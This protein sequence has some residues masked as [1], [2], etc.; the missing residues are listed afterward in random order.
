MVIINS[1]SKN[2]VLEISDYDGNYG[3]YKKFQQNLRNLSGNSSLNFHRK[4]NNHAYVFGSVFYEGDCHNNLIVSNYELNRL[5]NIRNAFILANNSGVEIFP[6]FNIPEIISRG[7]EILSRRIKYNPPKRVLSRENFP[8]IDLGQLCME[9]RFR[10]GIDARDIRQLNEYRLK[11]RIYLVNEGNTRFFLKYR[12]D[13]KDKSE[14]I[15]K[16]L[17]EIPDYFP[18]VYARKDNPGLYTFRVGKNYFGLEDF[19]WGDNEKEI[20]LDYFSLIGSHIGSLHNLFSSLLFKKPILLEK[21]KR[22]DFLNQSTVASIYL[23]LINSNENKH[24]YLIN[25]LNEVVQGD[26]FNSLFKLP[27]SLVH[28][29]LNHSNLIWNGNNPKIVDS[30]SI[31]IFRRVEEFIAPLL[32]GGNMTRPDYLKNSFQRLV[33]NYNISVNEPLSQNEIETALFLLRYSLLKYYVVRS[34]RRG[35]KDDDYLDVLNKNLR[36]IGDKR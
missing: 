24:N 25:S 30:E 29:D 22:G 7:N 21:L 23:D 2:S 19:I 27:V 33:D 6:I 26:L 20:N 1:E 36:E 17:N 15:S 11:N 35:I 4:D 31:G 13:D 3:E 10:Y 14:L 18:E 12:G 16:V 5:Q 9:L 34:I 8:E 28:R 32:L